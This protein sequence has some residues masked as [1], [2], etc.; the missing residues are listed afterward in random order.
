MKYVT[1]SEEQLKRLALEYSILKD[2][3]IELRDRINLLNQVAVNIENT[4]SFVKKMKEIKGDEEILFNI[5]ASVYVKAKITDI[6]KLIVNVGANT[7]IK[8]DRNYVMSYLE[9]RKSDV[10]KEIANLTDTLNGVLN[11]MREIEEILGK[12]EARR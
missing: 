4:L 2:N 12:M 8:R 6:D 9:E 3:V 11:R 5:G 1:Y 10:R 7:L